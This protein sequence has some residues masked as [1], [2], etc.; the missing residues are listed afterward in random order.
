MKTL[1]QMMRYNL[2][3]SKIVFSVVENFHQ[4]KFYQNFNTDIKMKS[5]P[6]YLDF[7]CSASLWASLSFPQGHQLWY[8]SCRLQTPW[9]ILETKDLPTY[10][11]NQAEK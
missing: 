10:S 6:F 11:T 3:I 2:V 8:L 4:I 5:L 1:I 9:R 7:N